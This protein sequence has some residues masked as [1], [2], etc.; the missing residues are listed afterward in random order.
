MKSLKQI[1]FFFKQYV[2]ILCE[3]HITQL[4]YS[5]GFVWVLSVCPYSLV[6][7]SLREH[8]QPTSDEAQI[9]TDKAWDGGYMDW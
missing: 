1:S 4:K 5:D 2:L 7:L 9:R 6:K 8:S 3:P